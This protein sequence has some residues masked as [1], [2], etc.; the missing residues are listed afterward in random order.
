MLSIDTET[1]GSDFFHGCKPFYV[2]AANLLGDLWHWEW[3]VDPYTREPQIPEADKDEI[4]H[5]IIT[6]KS[7]SEHNNSH[8]QY[9][10]YNAHSIDQA[11]LT[12]DQYHISHPE[13]PDTKLLIQPAANTPY[14]FN[15]YIGV[16]FHNAK[17]D[18]RALNSIGIDV[19]GLLAD[20][21]YNP[22]Q[23]NV[24]HHS[25]YQATTMEYHSGW[26]YVH[27]TVVMS[28]CLDSLEPHA[29]KYLSHKYLGIPAD[30]QRELQQAVQRCRN[31]APKEQV[32]TLTS[33]TD[34]PLFGESQKKLVIPGWRIAKPEDPHWPGTKQTPGNSATG[35]S[36]WWVLDSWL[37]AA[38]HKHV[39][40]Q[41]KEAQLS[42]EKLSGTKR[43][44][45]DHKTNLRRAIKAEKE[46]QAELVL[47][48]HYKTLLGTYGNRDVERT[49]LL[50]FLFHDMLIKRDLWSQYEQRRQMLETTYYQEEI[51]FPLNL[52][53]L[54]EQIEGYHKNTEEIDERLHMAGI[55]NAQSSD[56]VAEFLYLELKLPILERTETGKPRVN[57]DTLERLMELIEN[58][59][60]QTTNTTIEDTYNDEVAHS[61]LSLLL[62]RS[63]NATALRYAEGYRKWK[64]GNR[65]HSTVNITGTKELRQSTN[66][67]NVQ[68][69]ATGVDE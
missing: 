23:Q 65:I 35:E 69:I 11:P 38:Y 18:I 30:D 33:L 6:A 61:I 31:R 1:N 12:K 24:T 44:G 29:L 28:H 63:G 9:G 4:R 3:E 45:P 25:G 68:N 7:E 40:Q 20:T 36:G 48:E 15:P 54:E 27:D 10:L 34:P 57:K 52:P 62:Q 39:K 53:N 42:H 22:Q 46:L 47:T 43:R 17:F 14:A 21:E 26:N 32:T 51:G 13:D 5:L 16:V 56:Q 55:Q 37:P 58:G 19:I 67:P 66:N 2:S 49:I 41:Y 8:R 50:Y 64:T 60:D 59:D